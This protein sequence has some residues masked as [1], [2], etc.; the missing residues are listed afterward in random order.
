MTPGSPRL[1]SN[2]SRSP[3]ASLGSSGLRSTRGISAVFSPSCAML[4]S[5]AKG[6]HSSAFADAVRTCSQDNGACF[7][8]EA[9]VESMA[10]LRDVR[11]FILRLS[12][13]PAI[14]FDF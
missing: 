6:M 12:V 8:P 3:L 14:P 11:S 7:S 1:V 2:A 5:N 10:R 9:T 13:F 4:S